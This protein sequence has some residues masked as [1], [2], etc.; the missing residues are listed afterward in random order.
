MIDKR[1]VET[2]LHP[3]WVLSVETEKEFDLEHE[4]E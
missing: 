4:K 2:D 3:F 1:N